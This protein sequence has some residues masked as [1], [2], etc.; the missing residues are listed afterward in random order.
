MKIDYGKWIPVK[1]TGE[2]PTFGR[3]NH[4]VIEMF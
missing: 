1:G 4:S 2:E 3:Y